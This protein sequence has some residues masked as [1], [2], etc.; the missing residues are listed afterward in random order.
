MWTNAGADAQSFRAH[1]KACGEADAARER[2]GEQDAFL[3]QQLAPTPR[4][5]REESFKNSGR[6]SRALSS[7]RVIGLTRFP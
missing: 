1:L 4:D 2:A 3:W 5:W 7:R 6:S